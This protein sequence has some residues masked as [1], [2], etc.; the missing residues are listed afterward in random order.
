MGMTLTNT[1]GYGLRIPYTNEREYAVEDVPQEWA[2][3]LGGYDKHYCV[4]ARDLYDVL[5]DLLSEFD[6]LTYDTPYYHEVLGD[7]LVFVD[8]LS[9]SEWDTET[10]RVPD[11]PEDLSAWNVML[12]DVAKRI[13]MPPEE[14]LK[15]LGVWS[16]V[17][18][19]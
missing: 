19:G 17:S 15:N 14:F 8:E 9:E 6:G 12:R 2:A 11:L 7:T 5:Q 10:V 4:W 3:L 13:G 16:V 1:V 18:Y